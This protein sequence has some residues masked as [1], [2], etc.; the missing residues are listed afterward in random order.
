[1]PKTP[2]KAAAPPAKTPV[3]AKAALAPVNVKEAAPAKT[4]AKAKIVKTTVAPPAPIA[5]APVTPPPKSAP[6]PKLAAVSTAAPVVI[7]APAPTPAPKPITVSKPATEAPAFV[8]PSPSASIAPS[9]PTS[10]VKSMSA[11][12]TPA[13]KGFD[14]LTAFSKANIDAMVKANQIMAK[15]LEE[16]SKEFVS[17]TKSSMETAAATTKAVFAA[18]TL[19]D[20]VELN[21]G[22]T[23]SSME[24]FVADSTKLSEMSAKVASESFA[25]VTARMTV[26]LEKVLKPAAA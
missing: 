15:G 9:L 5:A 23:K 1:M 14:E 26:A 11:F 3:D 4:P 19:K 7:A 13:F 12:P 17:L 24:K 25:P 16:L 22:Y 21:K 18:K 20:V 8:A 6:S 10:M 2:I